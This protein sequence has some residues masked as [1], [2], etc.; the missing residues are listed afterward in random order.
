[1]NMVDGFAATS[2][3]DAKPTG[4]WWARYKQTHNPPEKQLQIIYIDKPVQSWHKPVLLIGTEEMFRLDEFDLIMP[5]P[6]LE[7]D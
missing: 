6:A 4:Y 5:V 2:D 3:A 7:S 1:M